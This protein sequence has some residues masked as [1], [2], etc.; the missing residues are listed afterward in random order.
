[1]DVLK[2]FVSIV[3][4]TVGL[5]QLLHYDATTHCCAIFAQAH[6]LWWASDHLPMLL[7]YLVRNNSV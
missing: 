6:A 1:M 7:L 2:L 4:R 5:L 3:L